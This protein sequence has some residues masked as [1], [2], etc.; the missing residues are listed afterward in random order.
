MLLLQIMFT[1]LSGATWKSE[2]FM[3]I[4]VKVGV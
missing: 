2:N 4:I 1:E 3:D